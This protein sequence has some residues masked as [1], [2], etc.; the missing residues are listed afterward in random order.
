MKKNKLLF[1]RRF[2]KK[3]FFYTSVTV[4]EILIVGSIICLLLIWF[5]GK[6][7]LQNYLAGDWIAFWIPNYYFVLSYLKEGILPLWQP[8]SYMGVPGAFHPGY[9]IFYPPLWVA[10]LTNLLINTTLSFNIFGKIMELYLY[11]HYLL[12]GISFYLLLKDKIKVSSVASFAGSF[13]YVFSIYSVSTQDPTLIGK[14]YLPLI[15]FLLLNFI[16]RRTFLSFILWIGVNILLLTFGYIYYQIYFFYAQ[17]FLGTL[18]GWRSTIST[19]FGLGISGLL[20]A[21][22]LLPQ[23]YYY[24]QAGRID[25]SAQ[26]SFH[27]IHS[28]FPTFIVDTLITNGIHAVSKMSWGTIPIIFLIIGFT[29]LQK[30]K[31]SWWVVITFVISL[32]FA[33]GGYI[34][35]QDLLGMPPFFL[36]KLRSHGQILILTFFT[37]CIL[38]ASGV[39]NALQGN[40]NNKIEIVLWSTCIIGILLLFI[41][42]FFGEDFFINNKESLIAIGRSLTLL[43]CGLILYYFT[44]KFKGILFI[45]TILVLT[46]FEFHYYY[47]ND[48][49]NNL[50]ASYNEYFARNSLLPELPNKDNLFRYEIWQSQFMYNISHLRAFSY[51]GYDG[52]PYSSV[53]TINRFPQ[54]DRYQF[55]NVK[56]VVTTLKLDVPEY[57]LV[58]K[59]NPLQHTSE[60]I[61]SSAEGY[62]SL[63]RTSTN[64]HYI[65]KV[66]NFLP[67]F[68]VPGQARTCPDSSCYNEENPPHIVYTKEE[69]VSIVNPQREQ[70]SI[71]VDEYTPNRI[72]LNVKTPEETFIASSEV[73]DRGW[74]V[75]VNEEKSTMYNVSNG[76]RGIV[77]PSGNSKVVMTYITPFLAE[78]IIISLFGIGIL[79]L[80]KINKKLRNLLLDFKL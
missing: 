57:T 30:N 33:F 68:Y 56:Y 72:V 36:D 20:S 50:G 24:L 51:S 1:I 40:K 69:N 32:I 74:K 48:E 63:S 61:F 64:I 75:K 58:K 66:N 76:F 73:W 5:L 34:G 71:K 6:S 23:A 65:Y 80:V 46:F 78:G 44:V 47:A 37:G 21:Y 45:A 26:A 49:H 22:V 3:S 7:F 29:V 14:M 35:L 17:I 13:I 25:D 10:F 54:P 18:Y 42:P 27:T 12:G 59:V 9:M 60:V 43:I 67:R 70:V 62:N 52:I 31:I 19:F 28:P 55:A 4:G 11:F 39:D 2:Y 53:Y 38:I 15:I 8:F 41:V 16:E 77:V 79:I